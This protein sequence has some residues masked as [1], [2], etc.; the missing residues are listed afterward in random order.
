VIFCRLTSQLSDLL[1]RELDSKGEINIKFWGSSAQM[2]ALFKQGLLK[3]GY[4]IACLMLASCQFG[5]MSVE[6]QQNLSK[7]TVTF[8]PDFDPELLPQKTAISFDLLALNQSASKEK[9]VR[10]T[11]CEPVE[12]ILL[13]ARSVEVAARTKTIVNLVSKGAVTGQFFSDSACTI[14]ISSVEF[15]PKESKVLRY[16]KVSQYNYSSGASNR[17]S[18]SAEN[19]LLKS[20]VLDA[21]VTRTV[22]KLRINNLPN[23]KI[24]RGQC[25]GSQTS[26]ITVEALDG[27]N[28]S[29]PISMQDDFALSFGSTASGLTLFSDSTCS[30]SIN[31]LQLK[32]QQSQTQAIWLKIPNNYEGT[33]ATDVPSAVNWAGS[34]RERENGPVVPGVSSPIFTHE[35]VKLTFD[36]APNSLNLGVCSGALTVTARDF[37][38]NLFNEA[39]RT[40]NLNSGT[41]SFY[42]T[43]ADCANGVS[44]VSSFSLAANTTSKILFFKVT[45]DLPNVTITASSTIPVV[46][47]NASQSITVTHTSTNLT[48][49]SAPSSLN[50]GVCSS[51]FN[52]IVRDGLRN[53]FNEVNRTINVSSGGVG[54][55]YNTAA[56]CANGVSAVSSFSLAAN[57]TSKILF[58][59]VTSDLPNVTI[60]ASSTNPVVLTNASQSITVTH[61]STNLTFD[62]APSSLNLGV[63]SSAIIL[64]LKDGLGNSF[65]DST[66]SITVDS[67]GAGLFYQDITNCTNEVNPTNVLL[68][69]PSV[70]SGRLFFKATALNVGLA[71]LSATSAPLNSANVSIT[72]QRLVLDSSFGSGGR[73]ILGFS[74]E[75]TALSKYQGGYLIAGSQSVRALDG[76]GIVIN[77]LSYTNATGASSRIRAVLVENTDVYFVGTANIAGNSDWIFGKL[78]LQAG[79]TWREEFVTSLDA[80]ATTESA[81]GIEAAAPGKVAVVGDKFEVAICDKANGNCDPLVRPPSGT[82]E[83]KKIAKDSSGNIWV[84]GSTN[85]NISVMKFNPSSSTLTLSDPTV[86]F[87][88][89]SGVANSIVFDRAGRAIV[90]GSLSNQLAL[91][92][93]VSNLTRDLS[94]GASGITQD[95]IS[96]EGVDVTIEPFGSVD[97]IL[98]SGQ[99]SNQMLIRRYQPNGTFVNTP[100][101][102]SNNNLMPGVSIATRILR[103]GYK[104]VLGGTS[105]GNPAIARIHP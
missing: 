61:T 50:L 14:S 42:T 28:N 91:F 64:S 75:V 23:Q 54:S 31:N 41:H 58:F 89:N 90:T 59:K 15:Q 52:V 33:Q 55:F 83:A 37:E 67:S 94:F 38:G 85:L 24:H 65:S 29:M 2:T 16:Y 34:S 26:P 43:A 44:A 77:S 25:F 72:L 63:C 8:S 4:L 92:R 104:I 48:F 10:L 46:L 18:F 30:T 105:N 87:P 9:K 100:P 27:L 35:A 11:L 6:G 68:L 88:G 76:N 102:N 20:L 32:K 53:P 56:D 60:T 66:R 12:V 84:V 97:N 80:G 95:P 81:I 45:S 71:T 78:T 17:L 51:Q 21:D 62:S 1:A 79:N 96:N 74:G 69:T 19:T 13:N 7:Q 98:I 5:F 22:T 82:N 47:T 86:F 3:G 103:D 39:N 73:N 36:N 99:S 40:I 57:T 49:D 70:P 101:I 93:L